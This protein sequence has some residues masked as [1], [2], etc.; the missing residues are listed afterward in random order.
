MGMD[1]G[2]V[3]RK[4]VIQDLRELQGFPQHVMW[5][6]V[7][8]L[9]SVFMFLNVFVSVKA[10]VVLCILFFSLLTPRDPTHHL[11]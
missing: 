5:L 6:P 7:A 8:R 11:S 4:I 1:S 3:G 2:H 9:R 10:I